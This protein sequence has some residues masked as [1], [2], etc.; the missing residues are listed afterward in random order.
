M[1]QILATVLAASLLLTAA[2]S[3]NAVQPPVS[4]FCYD[5][6]CEHTVQQS[7][8]AF[9]KPDFEYKAKLPLGKAKGFYASQLADKSANAVVEAITACLNPSG[10]EVPAPVLGVI[11]VTSLPVITPESLPE[12]RGRVLDLLCIEHPELYWVEIGDIPYGVTPEPNGK[13]ALIIDFSRQLLLDYDN[14]AQAGSDGA[15]ADKL[16]TQIA[17]QALEKKGDYE[18]LRYV[19]DWI[20]EHC[21]YK[22]TGGKAYSYT[23]VF[24]D[25]MAICEGYAKAFQLIT[26]KM[27]YN[28]VLV[29]GDASLNGEEKNAHM[30]N[31]IQI[32]NKWYMVDATWDDLDA[33]GSIGENQNYFLIG[34]NRLNSYNSHFPDGNINVRDGAF[35]F[36]FPTLAAEDY[37]RG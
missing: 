20:L 26:Q 13:S 12:L 4:A 19:H 21:E 16:A 23:G 32:G 9:L 8:T 22:Y 6:S 2:C 37:P 10:S 35:A 18:R 24:G 1:K 14:V 17:Q 36:A 30:W 29:C 3:A 33:Q 7:C 25:G 31:A 28:C 11:K 27:G 15:K 5:V 34:S